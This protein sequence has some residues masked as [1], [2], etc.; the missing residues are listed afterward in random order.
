MDYSAEKIFSLDELCALVDLPKRTV[1]Y[2]I[3]LGLVDHPEGETRSAYYTSEHLQQLVQVK[4]LTQ[5]GLSLERVGQVLQK[6][7]EGPPLPPQQQPGQY[8]LK[9]H[10]YLSRGV[11]LVVDSAAAQLSAEDIRSVA[12]A[13]LHQL[14]QLENIRRSK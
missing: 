8:A 10:I 9:T 4:A 2:Y 13:A 14:Q 7:A 12:N 11:E 6:A 1:R 3:Q 5:A